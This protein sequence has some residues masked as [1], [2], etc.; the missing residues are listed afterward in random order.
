MVTISNGGNVIS[1][2]ADPIN[3]T[4]TLFGDGNGRNSSGAIAVSFG[5]GNTVSGSGT[6]ATTNSFK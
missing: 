4:A 6:F 2:F 5:P 1:Q 3:G